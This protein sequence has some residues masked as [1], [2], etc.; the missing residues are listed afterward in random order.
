MSGY[1]SKKP[2]KTGYGSTKAAPMMNPTKPAKK[3]RSPK[4]KGC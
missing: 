4:G 1:G 2:T 3:P